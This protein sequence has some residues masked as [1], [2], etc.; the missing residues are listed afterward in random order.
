MSLPAEGQI[1]AVADVATDRAEEVAAARKCR[2][3]ADYRH[4]LDAHDIDAVFVA[5]PDHWHVLQSINACQAGKDV[6]VEKPLS[7]TIREGRVL[8]DAARRYSRVVQTGTQ[9][10][11]MKGH[12]YGCELVRSG[13]AG[14]I[15]TAVILNYPSPWECRFPGQPIP[16][17]LDWDAWCGM[18][19]PVP[20]HQDIFVQRSNPGWISLRPIRAER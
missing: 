11:S 13:V 8:V 17:G 10:R 4:V 1:V 2:A 7:L 19:E 15:H 9:R 3:C 14:K 6:Y 16:N 20:F 5:T 12:R 18:T